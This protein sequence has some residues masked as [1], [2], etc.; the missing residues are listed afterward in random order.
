MRCLKTLNLVHGLESPTLQSLENNQSPQEAVHKGRPQ[1]G[2]LPM[3]SADILQTRGWGPSDS[4]VCTFFPKITSDFSKFIVC[5]H[6]QGRGDRSIADIFRTKG[7]ESI[8]R[9][10]V[11]TFLMDGL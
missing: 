6:G 8:F 9:D 7:K 3:S 11:Q 5:L 10:F 1:S 2:G 4:D